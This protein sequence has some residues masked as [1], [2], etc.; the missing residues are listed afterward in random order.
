MPSIILSDDREAASRA[1][2]KHDVIRR[3]LRLM[4]AINVAFAS[5]ILF[6]WQSVSWF[7][8]EPVRW[9]TWSMTGQS[10]A[11]FDYPFVLLWGAPAMCAG[12]AWILRSGDSPRLA[13]IIAAFPLAYIGLLMACFHVMPMLHA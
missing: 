6:W 10:P 2:E 5:M 4:V 12:V 3:H 1:V 8:D 9:S 11:P 7:L 13:M